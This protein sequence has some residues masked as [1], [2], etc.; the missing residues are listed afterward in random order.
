VGHIETTPRKFPHPCSIVAP[1][2][3]VGSSSDSPLEGGVGCEL[4]S[5]SQ[6][7]PLAAFILF[8]LPP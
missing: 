2:R 5:E 8:I 6:P 4:V 7:K 3:L 1:L